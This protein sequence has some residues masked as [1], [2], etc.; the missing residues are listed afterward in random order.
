MS[1]MRV[2]SVVYDEKRNIVA[3]FLRGAWYREGPRVGPVVEYHPIDPQEA[4]SLDELCDVLH[5][6]MAQG[7]LGIVEMARQILTSP[8]VSSQM[9]NL[10]VAEV[11]KGVADGLRKFGPFDP[12]SETRDLPKHTAAKVRNAIVYCCMRLMTLPQGSVEV[13]EFREIILRLAAI[14]MKLHQLGQR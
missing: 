9:K 6:S 3:T 12:F 7:E 2:G 8:S 10:V 1:M 14:W 11:H 4:K 5:L 13:G